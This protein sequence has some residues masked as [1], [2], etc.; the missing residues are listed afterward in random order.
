MTPEEY[1]RLKEE[2][3]KH[4]REIRKIKQ[5]ART[6]GRQKSVLSALEQLN[7]ST[8]DLMSER[9]N[10]LEKLTFET[11]HN[12]AKLDIALDHAAEKA[13]REGPS[14]EAE[15]ALQKAKAQNL[16]RQIKLQMGLEQPPAAQA[17]SQPK[18]QPETPASI[19][20]PEDPA[21]PTLGPD[22]LPE[23]TLGRMK[24]KGDSTS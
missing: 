15:A 17:E 6:M 18:A 12:E 4:L 22:G 20:G 16:I 11:I 9:E 5:A 19:K 2:E 3:K 24:P 21:N 7:A 10:A 1:E 14:P 8:Q 23:K 13:A